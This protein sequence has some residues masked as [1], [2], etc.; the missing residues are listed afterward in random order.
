MSRNQAIQ[1]LGK[2]LQRVA[3]ED[4]CYFDMGG[5]LSKHLNSKAGQPSA[6]TIL[7]ADR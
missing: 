2:L 7:I 6:H 4:E 1:K 3:N 5:E